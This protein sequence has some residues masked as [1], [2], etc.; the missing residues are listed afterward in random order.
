MTIFD[1]FQLGA[2]QGQNKLFNVSKNW[3]MVKLDEFWIFL[4]KYKLKT[5]SQMRDMII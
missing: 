4:K 1:M 5:M 2:W 3:V